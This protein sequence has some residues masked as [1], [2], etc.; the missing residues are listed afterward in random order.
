MSKRVIIPFTGGLDSTYCLWDELVNTDNQVT[1]WYLKNPI[2]DLRDN[3]YSRIDTNSGADIKITTVENCVNWLKENTRDFT[4]SYKEIDFTDT[5]IHPETEATTHRSINTPILRMAIKEINN[6]NADVYI[7]TKEYDNFTPHINGESN[8][9]LGTKKSEQT[10]RAEAN[11]GEI[12]FKLL[13]SNYTQAV[14]IHRLPDALYKLTRSCDKVN[15]Y[16]Q[17]SCGKETCWKCKKREI[18]TKLLTVF[19]GDLEKIWDYYYNSCLRPNNKWVLFRELHIKLL[20]NQTN[21]TEY[22][23]PDHGTSVVIEE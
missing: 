15:T 23:L 16:E 5:Y 11:R 7:E 2:Q 18:F 13:D 21:L 3:G 8:Y 20:I 22:D 4:F 19:D 10:F 1:A 9:V 12:K 6:N 14:S 17:V